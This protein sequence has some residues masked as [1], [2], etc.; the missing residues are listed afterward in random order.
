MSLSLMAVPVFLDATTDP[1]QLFHQWTRMYHYGHQLMPTMAVAT[2]LLYGYSSISKRAA[3]RRWAMFAVAGMTTVVMLPFTWIV[4]APTNN[5]LFRLEGE[6]KVAAVTS[7]GEAQE[8]VSKW[9]LLHFVR[10][11]FPLAGALLGLTGTFQ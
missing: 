3:G 10:S 8:L 4:M 9:R 5:T 2:C 6:S 11:L 1:A 7:L